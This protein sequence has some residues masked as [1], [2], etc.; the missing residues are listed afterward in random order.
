[1]GLKLARVLRQSPDE[2]AKRLAEVIAVPDSAATVEAD[3]GYVNFRLADGWLQRLVA[4]V[5]PGYGGRD[6]GRGERLQVEFGSVNPTGP[7]H[8]GHGRGVTLGDSICRLLELTGHDV[9][10]GPAIVEGPFGRRRIAF[11]DAPGGIRLEFMEQ[12]S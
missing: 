12:L 11:V 1:M 10:W 4:R 5:E 7:L 8:I 9:V 3:K 2:I 6:I